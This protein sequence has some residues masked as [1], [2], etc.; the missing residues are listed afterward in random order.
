MTKTMLQMWPHAAGLLVV[1]GLI[2]FV[3]PEAAYRNRSGAC[4]SAWG[5]NGPCRAATTSTAFGPSCRGCWD[6]CPWAADR[7]LEGVCGSRPGRRGAGDGELGHA[8]G[9]L[10]I[11]GADGGVADGSGIGRVLH[12]VRSLYVRSP[13]ASACSRADAA[14]RSRPTWSRRP[15]FR[16]RASWPRSSRLCRSLLALRFGHCATS[17]ATPAGWPFAAWSSCR[18]GPD[19]NCSRATSLPT[20]PG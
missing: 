3:A 20:R 19:G 5:T 7:D 12:A 10:G 8:L 16:S 9:R 13:D 4:T 1:A 18:Y 14:D 6:G 15:R 17:G 2:A 11:D